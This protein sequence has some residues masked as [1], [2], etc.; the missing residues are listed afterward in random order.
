MRFLIGKKKFMMKNV[1][2]AAAF[3][4]FDVAEFAFHLLAALHL[5]D[6]VALKA[7][8]LRVQVHKLNQACAPA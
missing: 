2:I 7:G 1:F 5:V 6:K 3:L 8:H 4:W